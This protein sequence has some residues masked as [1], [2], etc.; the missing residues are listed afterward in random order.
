MAAP[1]PHHDVTPVHAGDLGDGNVEIGYVLDEAP[2]QSGH[3]NELPMYPDKQQHQY[4]R[5]DSGTTWWCR[6]IF[7]CRG[8]VGRLITPLGVLRLLGSG[9]VRRSSRAS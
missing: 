2:D 7:W 9:A 5:D 6:I 4:R 1:W 3:R 8:L